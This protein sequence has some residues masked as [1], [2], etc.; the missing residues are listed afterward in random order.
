L[1]AD[2]GD[3]KMIWVTTRPGGLTPPTSCPRITKEEGLRHFEIH[4]TILKPTVPPWN[5]WHWD[6]QHLFSWNSQCINHLDF[7]SIFT[8]FHYQ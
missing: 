1:I 4:H 3:A 6:T 2:I 8:D 7:G 5:H